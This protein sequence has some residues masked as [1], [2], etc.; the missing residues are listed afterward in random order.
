MW[1]IRPQTIQTSLTP[2]PT[3]TTSAALRPTEEWNTTN[4]TGQTE[5]RRKGDELPEVLLLHHQHRNWAKIRLSSG[6][7]LPAKQGHGQ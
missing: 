1:L 7:G 3:P 5:R 4:H 6:A 2:A